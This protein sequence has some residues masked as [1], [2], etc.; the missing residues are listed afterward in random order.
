MYILNMRKIDRD[1]LP[2]LTHILYRKLKCNYSSF[3]AYVT[4]RWWGIHIGA[5]CI[6][7]GRPRFARHPKSS[8]TIG[9]RCRFNSSKDS[10][11]LGVNHP[12]IISTSKEDAEII[13]GESCGFTGVSIGASK[14]IIIGDNVRCGNNTMIMDT[15]WHWNDP[16]TGPNAPVEIGDNVWLG[17]NVTVMKG[18]TIGENTVVAAGSIVTKALPPNVIAGGI[19]AKVIREL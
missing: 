8:I 5:G 10:T 13:I 12:C 19:P 1:N 7:H 18:V 3:W 2:D 17:I 11:V 4:A 9:S 15:D 6:F 14:K 16:R